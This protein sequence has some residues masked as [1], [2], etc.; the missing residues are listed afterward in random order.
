MDI[1][2]E[3]SEKVEFCSSTIHGDSKDMNNKGDAASLR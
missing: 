3:A 1:S 2:E